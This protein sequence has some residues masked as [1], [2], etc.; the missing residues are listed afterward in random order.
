M[1]RKQ[2]FVSPD[3]ASWKVQCEGTTL[4]RH[5]SR[6]AAVQSAVE[7]AHNYRDA[8]VLVQRLDGQWRTEWSCGRDLHPPEG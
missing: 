7:R 4:S 5:N 6:D 1:A 3:G 2:F 8:E